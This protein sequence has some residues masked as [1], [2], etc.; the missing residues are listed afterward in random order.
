MPGNRPLDVQLSRRRVLQWG[1]GAA[2]LGLT[3]ACARSDDTE[4]AIGPDSP[5]V[6]AFAEAESRRFPGGRPV[7]YEL[8]ATQS[9]VDLAG[10]RR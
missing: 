4:G 9:D 6:R 3:G 5:E 2:L 7:A 1:A 10:A 8:S